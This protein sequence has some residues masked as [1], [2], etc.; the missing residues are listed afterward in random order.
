MNR[1]R[2]F[3]L[4]VLAPLVAMMSAAALADVPGRVGRIA[5]MA[6][7]VQFYSESD[8]NWHHAYV[9]QPVTSRN[10]LYTGDGA[11][12]EISVGST[13]LAL[14]SD[15]QVD[16]QQLD[17]QTFNANV[18]R[19][20]VAVR[21]RRFE[22][23]DAYNLAVP[24]A[25]FALLKPGRYRIDAVPEGT[26]ITVFSGQASAGT[27]D[28]AV[29]VNAGNV[30]RAL[31][32]ASD[33]NGPPRFSYASPVPTALDDWFVAREERFREGQAARYVSPHMTGYEDLDAN[34]RWSSDVDYG[35]V[36]YPT[37]YVRADWVPYRYGRWAYV[38]PWGYTW[39]DDA[40]W[41]F[42]P[43]HYG[44]WAE[45][46]GR[47][48]WCPGAYVQRPVYAPALVGFYGGSRFSAS[49]SIGGGYASAPA[50]GWYPLAPWQRYA[51]HYTQ[52]VTYIRQV[53]NITIV[54]PPERI[55]ERGM[56]NV[57]HAEINRFRGGTIAPERAFIGQQSISKVAIAAPRNLV[58]SAPAV[59]ANS[60]PRPVALPAIARPDGG[61]RPGAG[62]PEFQ[63]PRE[64]AKSPV[65]AARMGAGRGGEREAARDPRAVAVPSVAGAPPGVNA[66]A[67]PVRAAGESE[68]AINGRERGALP[69]NYRR[70]PERELGRP[71]VGAPP[72]IGA[73][74]VAPTAAAQPNAA[75]PPIPAQPDR[76]AQIQRGPNVPTFNARPAP[77][78][79]P[80]QQAVEA[81]APARIAPRRERNPD[82]RAIGAPPAQA[83]DGFTPQVDPRANRGEPQRREMRTPQAPPVQQIERPAIIPQPPIPQPQSAPPQRVEQQHPQRIERPVDPHADPRGGLEG[84]RGEREGPGRVR[85]QER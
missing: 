33:P 55:R 26:G 44:R 85:Q 3:V 40:P 58:D 70:A 11:R 49:F 24:G 43:F 2:H 82:N 63:S 21:V 65:E 51:P 15:S 56:D 6:G 62:R 7:D 66:S 13:A 18:V 27:A 78:P 59:A 34:G 74:P 39:I 45:V 31:T 42:A 80:P 17:D 53:N 54:N 29:P 60:L 81:D 52:N 19:G 68:A 23:G 61:N 10:S 5:Y 1:V 8:P 22:A 46:G 14:D 71:G 72:V 28:G 83:H 73:A 57:N 36:W 50:V 30:L 32:S 47:W 76:P 69:P 64:F 16:I 79:L 38:A 25:D 84:P 77:A 4:F 20:R 48:G 41:G 35:P 12:A 37:T 9:N 75:Q 67:A